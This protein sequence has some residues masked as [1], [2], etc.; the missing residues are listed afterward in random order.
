MPSFGGRKEMVE[1]R[2]LTEA[3]LLPLALTPLTPFRNILLTDVKHRCAIALFESR[4]SSSQS[5][6]PSLRH[7]DETEPYSAEDLDPEAYVP[8]PSS[9]REREI[10]DDRVLSKTKYEVIKKGLPDLK[11]DVMEEILGEVS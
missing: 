1:R 11:R 7:G 6:L 3:D 4:F 8:R 9:E 5:H 10:A 2:S